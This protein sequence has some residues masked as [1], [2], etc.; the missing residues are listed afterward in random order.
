MADGEKQRISTNKSWQW[1][2]KIP[3]QRSRRLGKITGQWHD[4][5][6]TSAIDVEN[7]EFVDQV[8]TLNS[9]IVDGDFPMIRTSLM[10]SD[11]LM[12]SLGRP[13]REQ[14]VSSRPSELTTL[15]AID[16]TNGATLAKFLEAGAQQ[17]LK[18][19]WDSSRDLVS[20]LFVSSLSRHPTDDELAV[21]LETFDASPTPQ[22]VEDLL[23]VLVMMP[24]FMLIN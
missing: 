13:L 23:W 22:Q 10:N 19:K 5:K 24:E 3:K 17:I 9:R 15:E 8:K 20:H 14:I 18:K 6:V 2:D 1:C 21:I 11:F 12:R 4:A 7:H 16:L